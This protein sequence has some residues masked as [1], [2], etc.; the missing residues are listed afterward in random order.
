[1]LD[2]VP[3]QA[4]YEAFKGWETQVSQ[5]AAHDLQRLVGLIHGDRHNFIA[6]VTE[7]TANERDG[8]SEM[9]RASTTL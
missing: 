3:V 9:G 5:L 6:I 1:V 7:M 2:P 4:L 8:D